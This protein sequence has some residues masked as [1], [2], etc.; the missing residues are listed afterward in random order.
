MGPGTSV[1]GGA[2][3]SAFVPHGCAPVETSVYPS[4]QLPV[5]PFHPSVSLCCFSAQVLL[6]SF[7]WAF[8]FPDQAHSQAHSHND[9]LM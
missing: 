4:N 7:L 6:I 9:M 2:S 3:V 8:V 5:L 1:S